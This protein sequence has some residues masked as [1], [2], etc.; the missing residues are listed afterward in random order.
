MFAAAAAV[1]ARL[2]SE[3]AGICPPLGH[4]AHART[5]G[6]CCWL[7]NSPDQLLK[8]SAQSARVETRGL[9]AKTVTHQSPLARGWFGFVLTLLST[10]RIDRSSVRFKWWAR[11]LPQRETTSLRGWWNTTVERAKKRQ[12]GKN[13]LIQQK[14]NIRPRR[15]RERGF[16]FAWKR[17]SEGKLKV[18]QRG[19]EIERKGTIDQLAANRFIASPL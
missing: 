4:F 1:A 8:I 2:P 19:H 6:D 15:M 13:I 18:T 12:D 3:R 10:P 5:H 14:K 16:G 9:N 7:I 17:D 11:Q